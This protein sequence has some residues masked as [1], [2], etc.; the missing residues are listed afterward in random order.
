MDARSTALSL[1]ETLYDGAALENGL[2]RFADAWTRTLAT[3]CIFS[4]RSTRTGE[5]NAHLG[6]FDP[7]WNDE[8]AAYYHTVDPVWDC[9]RGLPTGTVWS[10]ESLTRSATDTQLEGLAIICDG[11]ERH[12]MTFGPNHAV[13]LETEGPELVSCFLVSR[14]VD[15]PDVPPLAVELLDILAPHLVNARRLWQQLEAAR[16]REAR[17]LA[18]LD[19]LATPIAIV[20]ERARVAFA[21]RGAH[22]LFGQGDGLDVRDGELWCADGRT[23]RA[24]GAAIAGAV[25]TSR[26]ESLGAGGSF[27][28]ARPSGAPAFELFVSPLAAATAGRALASRAGAAVVIHDPSRGPI[29]PSAHLAALY[30]LTPAEARLAAALATGHSLD[31]SAD[32]LSITKETART[33]LRRVFEKTGARRQGELIRKLVAG[34]HALRGRGGG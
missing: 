11:V 10:G 2:E 18:A 1:L 29:E 19:A 4:L 21:N 9:V 33:R 30:G 5:V 25:A 16:A 12:G 34:A 26:G 28:V 8:Y 14:F 23:R 24:L 31:E 17:W 6:G 7:V 20:D 32:A 22:A 15:M 3:P 27:R 13:V